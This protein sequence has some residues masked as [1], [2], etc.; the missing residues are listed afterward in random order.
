M[1]AVQRDNLRLIEILYGNCSKV[2]INLTLLPVLEHDLGLE[3][4]C[5]RL[6]SIIQ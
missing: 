4:N 3:I 5:L 6:I 1:A 2:T